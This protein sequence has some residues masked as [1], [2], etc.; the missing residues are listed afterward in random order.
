MLLNAKKAAEGYESAQILMKLPLPGM[1]AYKVKKI[2]DALKKTSEA[3]HAG[4]EALIRELGTEDDKHPGQFF[5][6][7]ANLKAFEARIKEIESLE[8]EVDD[9]RPIF[10]DEL[11]KVEFPGLVYEHLDWCI[12]KR[13]KTSP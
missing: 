11:E 1:V 8:E 2:C 13:P 4:R 12:E 7:A 10:L 6:H 9:V 3:F 5:I